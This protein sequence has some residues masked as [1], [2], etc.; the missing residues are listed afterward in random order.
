MDAV[1]SAGGIP[2]PGE[3]LYPYTLGRPK[4]LLDIHGKPMIQWVLEALGAANQVENV[5]LIGLEGDSGVTCSK[6]ITFIPNRITM[7]E[8]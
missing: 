4:A 3:L 2:I 7:I 8:N 1:L 6:P 5:V